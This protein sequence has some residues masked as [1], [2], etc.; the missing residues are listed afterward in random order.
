VWV[1]TTIFGSERN[2]FDQILRHRS[3]EA[4]TTNH[5]SDFARVTCEKHGSLPRRVSAAYQENVLTSNGVC[6]AARRAVK[7]SAPNALVD[8]GCRELPPGHPS[9]QH[10]AARA[11]LFFAVQENR[12]FR[13]DRLDV[14]DF[15]GDKDLCTEPFGLLKCAM[16]QFPAGDSTN[17]A[18]IVFDS[19]RRAA[20]PPGASCSI[21]SVARPSDPPYTAAASP[22]GPPPTITTSYSS[23]RGRVGRPSF[24]YRLK[25]GI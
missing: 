16:R 19:R 15:A 13:P 7:N 21:N 17:K 25:V 1:S 18:K 24:G 11:D 6:F 20:W 10:Y 22:A 8:T 5:N 3:L 12:E 23:N 9:C 4:G 14:F 2:L